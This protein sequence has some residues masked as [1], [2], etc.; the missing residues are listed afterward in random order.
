MRGRKFRRV[1]A[2]KAREKR[3]LSKALRHLREMKTY[4]K[5]NDNEK[6]YT[7]VETLKQSNGYTKPLFVLWIAQNITRYHVC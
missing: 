7:Q 6:C 5:R 1:M 3:R 2:Q 4:M